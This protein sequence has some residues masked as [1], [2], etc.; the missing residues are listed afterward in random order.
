MFNLFRHPKQD[1]KSEFIIDLKTVDGNSG[2]FNCPK[3]KTVISPDDSSEENYEIIDTKII[4]DQL[5]EL[6][7]KCIKCKS[8]I[9][10]TGFDEN[11]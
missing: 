2:S 6:I 8:I 4:N 5:S 9:K 3:C 10:L 11:Q 7:I 1:K